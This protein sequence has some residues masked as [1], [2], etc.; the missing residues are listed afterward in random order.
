MASDGPVRTASG[1]TD[2]AADG[3]RDLARR[4]PDERERAVELLAARLDRPMS[5]LGVLF[6]LVV[7]GQTVSNS[8]AVFAALA[9]T[10]GAYFFHAQRSEQERRAPV[11]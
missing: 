4:S 10:L 6:L 11:P 9:G 1:D 3:V 2:L 7:L 8:P 5:V